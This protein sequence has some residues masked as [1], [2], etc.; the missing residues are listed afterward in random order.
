MR[1]EGNI[2][3]PP[4]EA[5]SYLLQC[6]IGCSHNR[7]TFCAMYKDKKYRIR[8]LDDIKTD[9]RMAKSYHGDL[10]KIF[11]CDGD[12]LAMPTEMLI[13]IITTLYKTFPSLRHVGTYAGPDSIMEKSMDELIAIKNA[14]LTI[15]YLGV[16]TGD[17]QLLLDIKKGVDY[18][19]MRDAGIRFRAAGIQ[20]S[21]IVLLGLAG[22]G[23]RSGEHARATG[24]ILSEID[25]E[26]AGALTLMLVPGTPMFR[27][28]ERGEF[29]LPNEWE[30][31][32]EMRE[33][34]AHMEVNNCEFR[35]NHASNY[36][37]IKG[38]L[39]HDRGR[40]LKVI[41]DILVKHDR[42][43]L[44]PDYMRGL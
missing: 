26:Y 13:D 32:E 23:E 19:G 4:S 42:R 14:G 3:R 37:P 12:A 41:D 21:C 22:K 29:Q 40:L 39:P 38:H 20:L 36:L 44:R 8:D 2:F 9:I 27:Q 35:S 43:Y 1:Y 10:E 6:T 16:E 25:P 17:N 28:S 31:L 15:G 5:Y 30:V 7:C 33:L 18:E 34:I 24:K 11:L